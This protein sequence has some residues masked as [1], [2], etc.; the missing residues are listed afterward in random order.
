MWMIDEADPQGGLARVALAVTTAIIA[1]VR[2]SRLT[3]EQARNI[4]RSTRFLV[5]DPESFA[6]NPRA[7][8][9][10]GNMLSISQ[11]MAELQAPRP[12]P[13]ATS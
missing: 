9:E 7:A 6:P 4:F 10:A 11:A 1:E 13:C 8:E 12:L 5:R 3:T 2:R